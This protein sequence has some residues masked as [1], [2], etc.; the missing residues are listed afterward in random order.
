MGTRNRAE[1]LVGP[2]PVWD[3]G[4]D[5]EGIEEARA[6]NYS[7]LCLVVTPAGNDSESKMKAQSLEQSLEH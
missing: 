1:R 4:S 2:Q 3:L 7:V 6:W 5:V